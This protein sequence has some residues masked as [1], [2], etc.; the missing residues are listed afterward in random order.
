MGGGM[1]ECAISRFMNTAVVGVIVVIV[2]EIVDG[3]PGLYKPERAATAESCE[4]L[5]DND[6]RRQE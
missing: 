6:R 2:I 4:L 3:N 5:R 1:I